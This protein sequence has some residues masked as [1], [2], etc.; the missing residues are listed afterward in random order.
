[1]LLLPAAYVHEMQSRVSSNWNAP[2]R[3]GIIVYTCVAMATHSILTGA[4]VGTVWQVRAN[5][6]CT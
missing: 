2:V 3:F 1:M 4:T 5:Y 6:H